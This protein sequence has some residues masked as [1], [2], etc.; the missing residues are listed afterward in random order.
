MVT[1]SYDYLQMIIIG[2]ISYIIASKN[3]IVFGIK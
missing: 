3:E 2:D 1:W